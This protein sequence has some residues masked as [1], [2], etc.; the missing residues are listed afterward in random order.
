MIDNEI[1][2][3][4]EILEINNPINL[5]IFIF[6]KRNWKRRS[7]FDWFPKR[8]LKLIIYFQDFGEKDQLMMIV[9]RKKRDGNLNLSS[10]I[11]K[12][13]ENYERHIRYGAKKVV[14]FDLV[15]GL[16]LFNNLK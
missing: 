14:L 8:D 5:A 1:F 7:L 9:P 3:Q 11:V 13:Y 15:R 10:Q 6:G 4:I 16:E 2:N 12:S